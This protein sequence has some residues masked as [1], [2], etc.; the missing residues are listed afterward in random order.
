VWSLDANEGVVVSNK[1]I[2][3]SRSLYLCDFHVGYQNGKVDLY[4]IFNAARPAA[5]PFVKQRFVVFAQL[6]G[7][8]GDVPFFVDI[9]RE[10]EID[11]LHTTVVSTLRFPSRT[12]LMQLA[13]TVE[14]VHFP[15]PG[16][17]LVELFC[18]NMWV[19]DTPLTL[20]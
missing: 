10:G 9:R 6:T 4:G 15:E 8:L 13:L 2:P 14:G 16:V 7:G 18:H 20:R 19:C 17:Y 1:I 12:T 5:Y 11:A 3:V